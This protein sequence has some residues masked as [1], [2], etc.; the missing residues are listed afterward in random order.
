MSQ[1]R[2]LLVGAGITG[3][4]LL[5][6]VMLRFDDPLINLLFLAGIATCL[7]VAA[8]TFYRM[9]QDER[10]GVCA[11]CDRRVLKRELRSVPFGGFGRGKEEL[12][13]RKC[14]GLDDSRPVNPEGPTE[15]TGA[16]SMKP[17]G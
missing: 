4:V 7:V 17:E 15:S 1:S 5:V 16:T 10:T 12:W 2:G 8:L 9:R 13:C 11:R 3:T 14:R 6:G